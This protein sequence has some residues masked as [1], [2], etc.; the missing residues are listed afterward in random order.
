MTIYAR[1]T[2]RRSTFA[3]IRTAR[4]GPHE[5]AFDHFVKMRQDYFW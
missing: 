4:G 3:G 5:H 1:K 2:L